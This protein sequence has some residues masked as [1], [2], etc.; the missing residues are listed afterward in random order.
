MKNNI[1]DKIRKYR[2]RAG[3]S[4][5]DLEMA[6]G[7][8]HGMVS[9]IENDIVNPSKKTLV[10]IVETLDLN[11]YETSALFNLDVEGKIV[12]LLEL[13]HELYSKK[14]IDDV[15]QFAVNDIVFQLKLL[16]SFVALV[17]GDRVYLKNYTESWFTA[18]SRKIINKP[19]NKVYAPLDPGSSNYVVKS[20][21]QDKILVS[22][23]HSDFLVPAVSKPVAKLLERVAKVKAGIVL[24]LK[25]KNEMIGAIYFGKNHID[26][27]SEEKEILKIFAKHVAQAIKR[28]EK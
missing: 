16:G 13:A 21:M 6:I 10:S 23:N 3:M 4:Q 2:K 12:D 24:P 25:I 22:Y 1:G 9:R 11:A 18:L 26:D 19:M 7:A 14:S 27:F 5:M 8:S 28:Y 17:E 15:V 20:I